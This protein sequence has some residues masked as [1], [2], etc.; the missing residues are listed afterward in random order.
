MTV[1]Q[2]EREVPLDEVLDKVCV[3]LRKRSYE[4]EVPGDFPTDVADL[5]SGSGLTGLCLPRWLGG[6]GGRLSDLVG[7]VERIAAVDAATAWC[8]FIM[9]TAP[10]LLCH[11]RP[12]LVAEVYADPGTRVGGAL[13]PTGVIRREGDGYVLK[14]RWA[15]GSGV[16]ACDWVAVHAVFAQQSVTRSAFVL[17][18]ASGI[19]YREPWDGLGLASSGSGV[20]GVDELAVP[21][22]RVVPSLGGPPVW[23]DPPFR[24]SFR[25]TFGACSAILV[26]I[27]TEM[28]DAFTA[29]SRSKRPTFGRGLL[30]DQEYV[31]ILVAESW[32]ALQSARALLHRT[33]GLLEDACADGVPHPR[34]QAE[35]RIAMNTVRASCLRVV[36]QLHLAAGGGA[37]LR[38]SRFAHL[39]RD[40]HTA[41]QHAMFGT[42]VTA[43]AGSVLLGRDVPEGQL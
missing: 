31:Q 4:L 20:F 17:V 12:E 19:T 40:A 33:V 9:G 37:A 41:S 21:V 27:A 7:A 3:E 16:N 2:T 38:A 6:R 24:M 18:P 25:A 5:L 28:L 29:L 26:G 15:F 23:Q 39:L 22:H 10:W 35:L 11:A 13:A 34:Q 32:G 30:A 36:D 14:G 42:E 1:P 43:L 8:L